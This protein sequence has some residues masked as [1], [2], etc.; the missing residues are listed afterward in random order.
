MPAATSAGSP[1]VLPAGPGRSLLT[2]ASSVQSRPRPQGGFA[3]MMV[4]AVIAVTSILIGALFGLM[5]VTMRVTDAQERSARESRAADAAIETAINRLRTEQCDPTTPLMNGIAFDQQ[6]TGTGD[7][8]SVDVSCSSVPGN[9]TAADQVRI[10]GGDG[11]QGALRSALTT[12][13]SGGRDRPAVCRGAR[14][15][16]RCRRVRTPRTSHWSTRDPNR[17]ASRRA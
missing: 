15:S 9:D 17:C 3:L 4:L 16:G 13:C 14:R 12:D 6:T 2:F 8:V 10:V 5:L 1:A 7:D 11:Y